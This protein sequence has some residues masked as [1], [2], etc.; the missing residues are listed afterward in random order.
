MAPAAARVDG[1]HLALVLGH[2]LALLYRKQ[3][4]ARA[5]ASLVT[6]RSH[7]AAAG[8]TASD[9]SDDAMAGLT[10]GASAQSSEVTATIIARAAAEAAEAATAGLAPGV[11]TPMDAVREKA[12]G[13]DVGGEDG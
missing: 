2:R 13:V 1:L 9:S 11:P 7:V 3:C 6:R 5:A 10:P 4:T 8:A 12:S